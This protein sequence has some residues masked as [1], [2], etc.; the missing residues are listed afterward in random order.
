ML[1]MTYDVSVHRVS[2]G[3]FG[4]PVYASYQSNSVKRSLIGQSSFL[5]PFESLFSKK[6]SINTDFSRNFLK[7]LSFSSKMADIARAD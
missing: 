3:R 5:K 1:S 2:C 7:Q 4:L 6:S